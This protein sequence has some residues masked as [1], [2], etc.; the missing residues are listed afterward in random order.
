MDSKTPAVKRGSRNG[1]ADLMRF[2]FSLVIV[3][4]HFSVSMQYDIKPFS[5]GFIGVEFFFLLSGYLLAASLKKISYNKETIFPDVLNFLK[6][7]CTA[8]LPYHFII[9]GSVFVVYELIYRWR[10]GV[11]V[12]NIINTAPDFF[13]IQMLGFHRTNYMKMEWYISAMLIVMAILT[14]LI[15]RFRKPMLQYILP[16]TAFVSYGFI[17]N[18]FSSLD[19]L[20]EWTGFCYAGLIRALAG[21]S[22]GCFIYTITEAKLLDKLPR[23]LLILIELGCYVLTLFYAY[24]SGFEMSKY[25]VIPF[26][27][28][29]VM[30]T[31]TKKAEISFLNNKVT[32]F[33]GKWSLSVYLT[34][35]VL[36]RPLMVWKTKYNPGFDFLYYL[37]IYIAIE[38]LISLI[39]MF[40]VDFIM[41]LINEHKKKKAAKTA[42]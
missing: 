26:I 32:A 17:L 34:Q 10:P 9:F 40:V 13:F 6:K 5:K 39:L 33:L 19:L 15:I 18:S 28:I 20:F 27:I 30:I 8:F 12:K 31:F 2:V 36:K 16:I 41:K 11:L 23:A 3:I 21:I 42:E 14:P 35:I 4:F 24:N 7:K 25:A 1:M 22:M 29:A 37:L 38:L